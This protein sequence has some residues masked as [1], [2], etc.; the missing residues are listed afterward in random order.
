MKSRF[1][2]FYESLTKTVSISRR[3]NTPVLP[4]T[5]HGRYVSHELFTKEK[6]IK[7]VSIQLVSLDYYLFS[8]LS[9]VCRCLL[10]VRSHNVRLVLFHFVD[11]SLFGSSPTHLDSLPGYMYEWSAERLS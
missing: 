10:C 11:P 1:L 3:Y 9:E 4:V 8:L 2:F 7:K 6:E 5:Q